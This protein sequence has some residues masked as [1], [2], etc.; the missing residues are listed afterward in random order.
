MLL[1]TSRI[2]R[3]IET[4]AKKRLSAAASHRTSGGTVRIMG[5]M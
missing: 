4:P 2:K 3:I 5:R 1:N